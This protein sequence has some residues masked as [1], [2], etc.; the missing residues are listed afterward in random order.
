VPVTYGGYLN[1]SRQLI[2]WSDPSAMDLIIGD[3]AAQYAIKTED[4]TVDALVAGGTAAT[5][6]LAT[7]ANTAAQVAAAFWG[8]AGQVYA[9]VKG[10]G[11]LFAAAPPQMLGQVGPLFAP[12]NPT[13]AQSTGFTAADFSTGA[14]GSIAGIPLYVSAGIADNKILVMS[15][16]AAEVYEDRIG[17]LQVVEPSVLGVQVAYAGSFVPLI[18]QATGIIV[19]TKTP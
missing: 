19:I 15:T 9:A 11:R 12:V 16:A 3:L 6:N 14:V 5:T 2:D 13:D 10:A 1:V 17:S 18:L 8:A 4:V 7:G